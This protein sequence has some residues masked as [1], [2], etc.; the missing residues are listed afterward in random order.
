MHSQNRGN[1]RGASLEELIARYFRE[2]GFFAVRGVPFSFS[3]ISITDIDVWLYMRNSAVSREVSIVDV[4]SRRTPQAIERIFW[5]KGLQF[6]LHADRAMVATTDQREEVGAFG[7]ELGVNVLDG[8]FVRR[9]QESMTLAQVEDTRLTEEEFLAQLSEASIGKLGG[10]WKGRMLASKGR[11]TSVLSFDSVLTWLAEATYFAEQVGARTNVSTVAFRCLLRVLSYVLIGVDYVLRDVLF[12]DSKTK[13]EYLLTGLAYGSTGREGVLARVESSIALV[14][15]FG[16]G[17]TLNAELVRVRV[18]K[19]LEQLPIAMLAEFFSRQ[20][21]GRELFG[22]ARE[23]D[24]KS[25]NRTEEGIILSRSAVAT[26]GVFLDQFGIERRT[27]PG[28]EPAQGVQ[29]S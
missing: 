22:L 23:F 4:K 28:M 11:L 26:L 29:A 16:D 8:Y 1:A 12:M 21:V 3:A 9:L 15:A 6:A 24:D 13:K 5:T 18:E 7:R 19:A 2:L 25:M 14:E 27:F 17:S 20:E 10:D